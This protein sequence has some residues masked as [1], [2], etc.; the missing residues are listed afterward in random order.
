VSLKRGILI[1]LAGALLLGCI[2]VYHAGA[3]RVSIHQKTPD[4]HHLRL[5]A[6]AVLVPV[7]LRFVP[8]EKLR[9]ASAEMQAW[10]P[11]IKIASRELARCPD[12]PLVEVDGP[13]EKVSIV[14]RGSSLVIDV[15]S[16]QETVHI[17]FPLKVV[18]AVA[19]RLED[20]GPAARDNRTRRIPP[21]V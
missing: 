14:K 11:A 16:A 13:Q 1:G 3:V 18:T 8:D 17:S 21:S 5:I 19:R 7:V 2:V 10:L 12:G 6:P 4:G 9:E 20:V 15:N